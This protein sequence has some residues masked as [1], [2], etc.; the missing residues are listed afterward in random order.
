MKTSQQS[1]SDEV[2]VKCLFLEPK[3]Q[4]PASETEGFAAFLK[5]FS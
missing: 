2:M 4:F 5:K 3:Y 1:S